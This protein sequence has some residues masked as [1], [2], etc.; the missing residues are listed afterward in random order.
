MNDSDEPHQVTPANI[1]F[2]FQVLS[3]EAGLTPGWRFQGVSPNPALYNTQENATGLHN[4]SDK[5]QGVKVLMS[6]EGNCGMEPPLPPGEGQVDTLA[7][8]THVEHRGASSSSYTSW[9]LQ[10]SLH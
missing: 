4:T 3:L 1:D 2:Y 8:G 7:S 9:P 5:L 10:S 6:G